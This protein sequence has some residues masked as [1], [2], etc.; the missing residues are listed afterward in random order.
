MSMHCPVFVISAVSPITQQSGHIFPTRQTSIAALRK[1]R[2]FDFADGADSQKWPAS[3][4]SRGLHHKVSV[5]SPFNPR[6]N[7]TSVA[8]VSAEIRRTPPHVSHMR[9]AK[10]QQNRN[11]A[12]V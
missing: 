3:K 5:N 6:V 12:S 7:Y 1:F 4:P 9:G 10:T 8:Y 11:F 2:S